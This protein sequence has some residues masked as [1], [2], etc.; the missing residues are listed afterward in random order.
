MKSIRQYVSPW[1][2]PS[3]FMTCAGVLFGILFPLAALIME[4][5]FHKVPIQRQLVWLLFSEH[6]TMWIVALAPLVLGIAGLL[7]GKRDEKLL[8]ISASLEETVRSQTEALR[9]TNI[10]LENEIAE[11]EIVQK[12]LKESEIKFRTLVENIPAIVYMDRPDE[13]SSNIYTSPQAGIMLGYAPQEWAETADLWVKML[14]PEDRERVLAE[15]KRANKEGKRFQCEYRLQTRDGRI[16]WV[17]DEAILIRDESGKP[18][19]WQGIILD[20]TERKKTE[21]EIFRQ[22]QY[23]ETLLKNNPVAIVVLDLD[24]TVQA[25]NPAFER[26]FGYTENEIIGQKLDPLIVPEEGQEQAFLYT[27]RVEMGQSVHATGKRRTK[28]GQLIDVEIFGVPVVL[29][30]EQIG[31]LAL[32][33]DLTELVQAQR[34]AEAAAKAKAEFLANMSHEIRTPLN[35]IVG[36]TSLL[37]NTPLNAEQQDYAET[38]RSSSDALLYIIN[39]ILDFSKIEAGKMALEKHPFYLSDC[40]E[41]ALDLVAASATQKGLD[42]AYT[43][44]DGVP[45]KVTGDVTRLR[46]VLVNLLSNAVK[47]TEQGEI[48]VSV[49]GR[50]VKEN[51]Y[52]LLFSVRDTGIGIPHEMVNRLFQAFSQIDASTTRKYG[53]TGLGLSISK[54]LVEMMGG[55]IWVE[56]QVGSG[57]TFSFTILAE[58]A[59]TTARLPKIGQQPN[60]RGKRILIVDDNATNRFILERQTQAW[61]MLPVSADSAQMALELLEREKHFDLVIL[62]M[63][64]PEMDGIALAY[65]IQQKHPPDE[66][67]LVMLTSLGFRQDDTAQATFAAYLTKPIK[68]D[69]L[70]SI[71]EAVLQKQSQ[72]AKRTATLTKLDDDLGRQHPLRILVV[73]DNPVNQKVAVN[74]LKRLGYLA[75]V[76]YNGLEA[77]EALERQEY[78]VVFMDIQ[79]PEMDGITAAAQIRQRL[80]LERTP[81]LIA[82][83]ADALEGDRE[84]YLDQGMDDYISKPVRVDE[85]IEALQ[86]CR[87]LP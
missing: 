5:T 31:I 69:Q 78:D 47:F 25:C 55:R 85:L 9:E 3:I 24:H 70:H 59:P 46:Q 65:K 15:N 36:M 64:M 83:T 27:Q 14:H 73:E 16:V 66:L 10:V 77:I 12:A 42:L 18:L 54:R 58:T 34:Q 41:T 37:L 19:Y 8:K 11:R 38:I 20:I 60:L 63:H 1:R 29:A 32:Y 30:G 68:P 23:F 40:I 51:V 26:L 6:P 22:K 71:L 76:S 50:Q 72:P 75:D 45:H 33:H 87:P 43:I 48:V 4:S 80:P 13:I 7:L 52:E 84:R 57:S 28:D 79:M 35:A 49:S 86:K 2:R 39:D 62:D 56:S 21:A 67:P 44:Q 81:R 61:G 17:Q 74:L 53:G 82:M